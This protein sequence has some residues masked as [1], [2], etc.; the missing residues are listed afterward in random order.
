MG[1]ADK[2]DTSTLEDSMTKGFILTIAASGLLAVAACAQRP[3]TNTAPASQP[4]ASV[5]SDSGMRGQG[6]RGMRGEGREA[7]EAMMFNGITLSTAQQA[8]IDSIR[9]RHRA[10]MQGL[11]P[12]NNADDRQKMMQ[13]RQAQMAEVRA[14][15]TPDQQVVFDQ[16]MQQMR[17][18]RGQRDGAPPRD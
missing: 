7:M 15:L 14:V 17:D 13:S 2:T 8:Q 9:T 6:R 12:R 3:A 18:R 11:D 10:D 16:N 4:Q 1:A 5:A